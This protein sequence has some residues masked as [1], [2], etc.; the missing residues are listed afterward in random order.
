MSNH[1]AVQSISWKRSHRWRLPAFVPVAEIVLIIL[2]CGILAWRLLPIGLATVALAFA[3]AMIWIGYCPDVPFTF[4][5]EA[6]HIPGIS[7]W[8]HLQSENSSSRATAHVRRWHL[9]GT[10]NKSQGQPISVVC[11]HG[12][13]TSSH[14]FSE[15]A[16]ELQ[17]HQENMAGVVEI[18]AVDLPGHGLTGPWEWKSNNRCLPYSIDSDVEFLRQLF[19]CPEMIG[20][21]IILVGHSIGG[22]IATAY[23][24]RYPERIVALSLLAPWGLRHG[25]S[26]PC[27][28]HCIWF[29]KFVLSPR[30]RFLN[31]WLCLLLVRI[32]PRPLVQYAV[33]TAFGP[34]PPR[35]QR[36]KI[37]AAADHMQG[38][39]VCGGNRRTF[40][41]RISNFVSQERHA[42]QAQLECKAQLAE[43]HCPVQLQWGESDS[44]L[45]LSRVSA[46]THALTHCMKPS[47]V[48]VFPGIGHCLPEQI[49]EESAEAAWKFFRKSVEVHN[50][51]KGFDRKRDAKQAGLDSEFDKVVHVPR[52]APPCVG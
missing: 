34:G 30:W 39:M 35:P 7:E 18:V 22:R 5:R 29:V 17:R 41:S 32:T 2:T 21:R 37:K 19:N 38:F 49:P 33:S 3:A 44:W 8:W 51:N 9:A 15:W 24:A 14:E 52:L 10:G 12:T 36:Q 28:Q 40:V 47:D 43:I 42:Q 26:D 25:P 50:S 4:A 31:V 46:W 20:K 13:F 23:T 1:L 11:L 27:M 45:H 48:V 16:E 6:L